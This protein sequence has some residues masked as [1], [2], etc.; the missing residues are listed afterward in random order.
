MHQKIGLLGDPAKNLGEVDR[1]FT[2]LG[3]GHD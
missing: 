3:F 1:A 2:L